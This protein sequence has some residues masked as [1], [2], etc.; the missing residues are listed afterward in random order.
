VADKIFQ[1]GSD[2]AS[3][4]ARY[5][6]RYVRYSDHTPHGEEQAA[7]QAVDPPYSL[8]PPGSNP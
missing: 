5:L 2:G 7:A 1:K 3:G 6:Q 8:Q 4:I